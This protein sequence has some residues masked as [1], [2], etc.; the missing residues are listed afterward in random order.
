MRWFLKASNRI[1]MV[2]SGDSPPVTTA[3][4]GRRIGATTG[5]RALG[6]QTHFF[7][8]NELI[9]LNIQ[10]PVSPCSNGILI[11]FC[12][13]V[14]LYDVS[15]KS[16]V[17]TQNLPYMVISRMAADKGY[18]SGRD[19]GSCQLGS[20]LHIWGWKSYQWNSYTL[21]MAEAN[22]KAVEAPLKPTASAC[23]PLINELPQ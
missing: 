18:K 4:T 19:S 1:A 12:I 17:D 5:Q 20:R 22:A 13:A 21:I 14:A 16:R 6:N 23:L 7:L 2:S 9:C 15:I 11:W 3:W 10:N 8:Y